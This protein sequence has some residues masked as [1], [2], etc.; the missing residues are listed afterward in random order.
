[1]LKK[2][3]CVVLF[4]INDSCLTKVTFKV[5]LVRMRIYYLKK[6]SDVSDYMF[7]FVACLSG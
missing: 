7:V 5:F 4:E 1:M 3:V 2:T 6:A